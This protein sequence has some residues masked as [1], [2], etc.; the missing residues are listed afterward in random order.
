MDK[1]ELSEVLLQ[2]TTER[3]GKTKFHLI[4]LRGNNEAFFISGENSVFTKSI[5]VINNY[6]LFL[7]RNNK[8][9]VTQFLYAKG[10]VEQ[11][12]IFNGTFL[13]ICEYC[14]EKNMK[15]VGINLTGSDG[16][17]INLLYRDGTTIDLDT[18][19]TFRTRTYRINYIVIKGEEAEI[20]LRKDFSI[21]ALG[22]RQEASKIISE[23]VY[24][25]LLLSLEAF[26]RMSKCIFRRGGNLEE[27]PL[28][29]RFLISNQQAWHQFLSNKVITW[30]LKY[31]GGSEM[32]I[33][34]KA[35]SQ[36]MARAFIIDNKISIFPMASTTIGLIGKLAEEI[37]D[38]G[39]VFIA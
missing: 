33:F 1:S 39:G 8:V 38:M 4:L 19:H 6:R 27:R 29:V 11:L 30:R 17:V 13:K 24:E 16:S 26:E 32:V 25:A 36:N 10:G 2:I 5:P 20:Y 35:D 37:E 7:L 31:S 34:R 22:K 15:I 12:T 9:N 21:E 28:P 3:K 18:I 14:N 23:I